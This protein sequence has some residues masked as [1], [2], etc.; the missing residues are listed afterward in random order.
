MRQGVRSRSSN[1]FGARGRK[2]CTAAPRTARLVEA[3]VQ[4]G[5]VALGFPREEVAQSS[6][7]KH[8]R[9]RNADDEQRDAYEY[10]ARRDARQ[11]FNE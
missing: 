8:R 2:S 3:P 4:A 11:R 7:D 10:A 5:A 6:D 9:H 1:S